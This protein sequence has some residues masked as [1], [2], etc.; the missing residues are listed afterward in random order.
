MMCAVSAVYDAMKTVPL[1]Q[2]TWP[3]F[4]EMKEILDKLNEID[5]KLGQPDCED[6]SKADILKTIEDRLRKLEEK[7]L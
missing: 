2:W 4:N 3:T 6:P 5:R 1:E 7:V